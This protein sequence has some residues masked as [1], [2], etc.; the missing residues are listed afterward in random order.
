[1]KNYDVAIEFE[2][3]CNVRRTLEAAGRKPTVEDDRY[4]HWLRTKLDKMSEMSD[5][6]NGARDLCIVPAHV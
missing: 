6:Q 2:K 4:I 1:M 5:Y 3:A